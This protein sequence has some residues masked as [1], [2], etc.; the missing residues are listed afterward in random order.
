MSLSSHTSGSSSRWKRRKEARPEEILDAALELFTEKGFSA[1]RM[2]DVARKAGISKGTL[3]LYFDSKEA[4]FHALIQQMILPELHKVEDR[5]AH[6]EGTAENLLRELLMTWWDTVIKTRLSAI[7]KLMIS[8][9]GNFPELAEFF[10]H[11]VVQRARKLYIKVFELGVK[12]GEFK[13]C[14]HEIVARLIIAPLI[15]AAVWKHS[16]ARFDHD[17]DMQAYLELHIE[18]IIKGLKG[19]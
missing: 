2:M 9:S 5:V 14:D 18:F 17:Y 12:N 8:E 7:P 10:T 6:Y 4:I 11:N 1:A 15:Q 3:Y 13:D 19:K 16:L